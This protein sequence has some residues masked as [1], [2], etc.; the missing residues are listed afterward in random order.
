MGAL[1]EKGKRILETEQ[2]HLKVNEKHS[3]ST[4]GFHQ[5]KITDNVQKISKYLAT[6]KV[7]TFTNF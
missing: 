1:K 4:R 7:S 2:Y 5:P 3:C 6:E